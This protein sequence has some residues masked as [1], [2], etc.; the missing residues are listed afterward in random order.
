[1]IFPITQILREINFWDSRS[2]KSDILTNLEALNCDV[3]EFLHFLKAEI[4][5]INYSRAPKTAK[6]AI[7]EVLNSLKLL[8][9][10][11]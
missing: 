4:H 10:K 9:R 2:A 8:S 6:T 11:I 3:N 1:M 5:Q 7:S